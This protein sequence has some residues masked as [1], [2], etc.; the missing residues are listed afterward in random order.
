MYLCHAIRKGV[1]A[2][3]LE[4]ERV[5]VS[6]TASGMIRRMGSPVSKVMIP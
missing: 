3:R 1:L 6:F 5:A 4:L 2:M